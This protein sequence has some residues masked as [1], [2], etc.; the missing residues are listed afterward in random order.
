MEDEKDM[1]PINIKLSLKQHEELEK[2]SKSLGNVTKSNLIRI[3]IAEFLHSHNSLI[4][5]D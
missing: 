1:K 3:A 4:N 5:E 2:L